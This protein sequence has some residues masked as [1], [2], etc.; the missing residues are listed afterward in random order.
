MFYQNEA[1]I[2]SYSQEKILQKSGEGIFKK[3]ALYGS[4]GSKISEARLSQ[5]SVKS[6]VK[7]CV[8][9][10]HPI[11][12]GPIVFKNYTTLF[13][14]NINIIPLGSPKSNQNYVLCS[15]YLET[16]EF[17]DAPLPDKLITMFFD[18]SSRSAGTIT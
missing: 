9:P 2:T 14:H 11:S 17:S 6:D 15:R 7:R 12:I 18:K 13:S 4:I 16:R 5:V 1:K 3:S 10:S 8:T